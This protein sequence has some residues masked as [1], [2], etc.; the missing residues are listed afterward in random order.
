M[1]IFDFSFLVN[2]S[3]VD[4]REFHHGTA[5]LKM[6]TPP[7]TIVQLHD[8]EPLAEGSVSRFTLWVGPLPIAWT[9]VHR[10]VTDFGFTDIQE[11]GPAKR[12]EHIHTFSVVSDHVTR[13]SEHIEYEHG[14]GFWGLVTRVLFAK[15]NLYAM[16]TYRKWVTQR[17][18][19]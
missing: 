13:V 4:V 14:S 17:S 16:F 5:A 8:I 10:N 1:P 3:L 15:P 7:P 12:W 9:A 18:L 19:R 2:A 11:S 6:L